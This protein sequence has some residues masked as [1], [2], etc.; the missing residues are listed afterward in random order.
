MR[1]FAALLLGLLLTS[2]C[3]MVY[4]VPPATGRVV[5]AS[6]HQPVKLA[7]VTRLHADAPAQTKTDA[8]GSQKSSGVRNQAGSEIKRGQK[9]RAG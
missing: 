2:G 6:S 5:D 1:R 4:V 3:E 8:A 9:S 7:Q